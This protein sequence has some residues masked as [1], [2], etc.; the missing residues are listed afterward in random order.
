MAYILKPRPKWH[1]LRAIASIFKVLAWM[2][3]GCGVIAVLTALV[4]GT[5]VGNLGFTGSF[6][7]AVAAL[8]GVGTVFLLLYGRAEQILLFI[9]IE[10]NTRKL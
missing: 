1:A 3:A 6:V 2:S 5:Q 9:A 4:T 10:E 8:I 7:F